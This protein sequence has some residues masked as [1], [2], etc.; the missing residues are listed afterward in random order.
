MAC[1]LCYTQFQTTYL[2][3]FTFQEITNMN[4]EPFVSYL[5]ARRC[6]L[7]TIK[8]YRT[9]LRLFEEFLKA[10]KLR[11]TQVKSQTIDQ[12]VEFLARRYNYKSGKDGLAD[13]SI[14]RRLAAVSSLFEFLR[15]SSN[16]KI[17]N[18]VR[19]LRRTRRPKRL[20]EQV[21]EQKIEMLLEGIGVLRDKAIFALFVASG[22]RLSELHQLDR[23]SIGVKGCMND[24]KSTW[25]GVGRVMG[26]GRKE[27]LF[28]VDLPTVELVSSYLVSRGQDGIEALFVSC[29]GKR[30]SRRAIQERLHHWCG[31]LGVSRLR[32]HALRHAFATRLANAGIPSLVLQELMGH[33]SFTVT[34]QYFRLDETRLSQEYFSA[35]ELIR[36][37]DDED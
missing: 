9:D 6:S 32:V 11:V 26:K 35:M 33:E 22:L 23:D 20:P 1:N 12:F 17:G 4:I 24:G 3:L 28:L 37:S 21:P 27:R 30:M 14:R 5:R 25:L 16:G 7:E 18:P 36:G 19:V 10:R 2:I 29:R 13:A 31:H 8:A 34:Q 15:G